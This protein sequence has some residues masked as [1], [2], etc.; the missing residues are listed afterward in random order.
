MKNFK[1]NKIQEYRNTKLEKYRNPQLYTFYHTN[2]HV[3]DQIFAVYFSHSTWKSVQLYFISS[4]MRLLNTFL[5]RTN[6]RNCSLHW[7]PSILMGTGQLGSS[8]LFRMRRCF[9]DPENIR[10]QSC[11]RE[12]FPLS[13]NF[14]DSE[15]HFLQS[16]LSSISI[17]NR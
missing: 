15:N 4:T 6:S 12:L 10:M 17:S 8:R 7:F 9:H 13:C 14:E 16:L 2:F 5:E 11:N 1:K 3:H